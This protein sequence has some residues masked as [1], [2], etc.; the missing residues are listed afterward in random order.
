MS[1]ELI[2]PGASDE[3]RAAVKSQMASHIDDACARILGRFTRFGMEYELRET[4][5]I[6]FKSA[7][8]NGPVPRQVAAFSTRAG[9]TP[10]QATDIILAQATGYRAALDDLG[11]LRMRKFELIGLSAD[12]AHAT[13][14]RIMADIDAFDRALT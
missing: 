5:A 4:Q 1:D 3:D 6:A 2:P 10:L 11:D 12:A 7:A 8:Y 13:Y 9:I 14:V